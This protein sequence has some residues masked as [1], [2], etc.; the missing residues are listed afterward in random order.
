MTGRRGLTREGV[1]DAAIELVEVEGAAALSLSRLARD[2]R[3]KPPSL[4]NHVGGLDS[5][6]RDIGLRVVRTLTDRLRSAVMGRAGREALHA[7]SVEFRSYVTA[8]PHLY[9]F[10]VRARPDD[11]EYELAT[12]QAIEPVLIVLRSYG[13][14]DADTIHAARALRSAL[15]GFV[16]LEIAGGFGFDVDID[17]SFHRLIDRLIDGFESPPVADSDRDRE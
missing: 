16:S 5:L 6:H 8:H 10:S 2:L 4:Y 1:I 15:H 9:E 14:D 13:L 3:V 11:E 7:V 12:I 17:Q